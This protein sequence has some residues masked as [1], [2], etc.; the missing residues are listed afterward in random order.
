R[1]RERTDVVEEG[2]LVQGMLALRLSRSARGVDP[3]SLVG[4]DLHLFP[5]GAQRRSFGFCVSKRP[6]VVDTD[7]R[8]RTVLHVEDTQ[9]AAEIE[10]ELQ[11][12]LSADVYRSH[13]P[14]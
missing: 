13:H 9:P 7:P 4:I 6:E 11:R 12:G 1:E 10:G 8:A 2:E 3:A 5:M 14:H